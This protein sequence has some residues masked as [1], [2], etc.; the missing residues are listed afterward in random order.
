M[1]HKE[2][3][4]P[5]ALRK[6]WVVEELIEEEPRLQRHGRVPRRLEAQ[7]PLPAG[8]GEPL[9]LLLLLLEEVVGPQGHGDETVDHNHSPAGQSV[10]RQG[11]GGRSD[12]LGG[13]EAGESNQL[14]RADLTHPCFNRARADR[15]CTI[16]FRLNSQPLKACSPAQPAKLAN[17]NC[18]VDCKLAINRW[19]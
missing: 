17:K 1:V 2:E 15:L 7:R 19:S 9:E 11:R 4:R 16:R 5:R 6:E 8:A 18:G 3:G 13:G 14:S 10:K 12:G